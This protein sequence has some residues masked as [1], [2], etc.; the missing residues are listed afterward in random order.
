MTDSAEKMRALV[1]W[2]KDAP[3]SVYTFTTDGQAT[4]CHPR[5]LLASD[6][7]VIIALLEREIAALRASG[8]KSDGGHGGQPYASTDAV[9][10]ASA[11]NA[12]SGR[13]EG[14]TGGV[15]GATQTP[16]SSMSSGQTKPITAGQA[17]GPSDPIPSQPD[18]RDRIQQIIE[19]AMIEEAEIQYA[20]FTDRDRQREKIIANAADAILAMQAERRGAKS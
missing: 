7:D 8:T 12:L 14:R 9:E 2:L 17:P 19:L 4:V 20:D 3:T 18:E 1:Q 16:G 15:V 6:R 5:Y 10:G 13:Q 11:P